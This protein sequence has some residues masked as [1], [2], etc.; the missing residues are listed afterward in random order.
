MDLGEIQRAIENLPAGAER[1]LQSWLKRRAGERRRSARLETRLARQARNPVTLASALLWTGITLAC[2][3][4]VEGAVFHSGLYSPYLEPDSSAGVLEGQMT[5]LADT[6]PGAQPEILVIGDSR[7]AEGFSSRTAV[8][9][10]G[11]KYAIWNL[12]VPGA[13]PRIWYYMLRDA[14][15][16]HGEPAAVVL[17]LDRFSDVDGAEKPQSRV[18][19]LNYLTGRLRLTDCVDFADSMEAPDL[20]HQ[21]IGGCLFRG[22]PLRADLHQMLTQWTSRLERA[23]DFRI[24]G[25]GYIDGYGGKSENLTGLSADFQK[26]EIHFPPGTMDGQRDTIRNTVLPDPVPQ[27]GAQYRYRRLWLG[28]I[29]DLFAKGR[30]RVVFVEMPRAPLATPDSA[31][32]ARFLAE[33]TTRP[34]VSALPQDTFHDLERPEL[35][36]D[37]LH[38]NMQ[39]RIIFS[40]RLGEKL[41]HLLEAGR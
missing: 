12:G 23:R 21:A 35:F 17:G 27:T 15:R 28:R 22:M 2:F 9:A 7:T 30:T 5:W 38:L 16:T 14:V 1:E 6:P 32:A 29:V 26:R 24:H 10:A 37:G 40:Q 41:A 4:V 33:A 20:W 39:G 18:S 8:T 13:T 3:A 36:A 31:V 25:H 11:G 34:G 19:D